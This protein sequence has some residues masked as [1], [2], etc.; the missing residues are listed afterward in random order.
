MEYNEWSDD[1]PKTCVIIHVGLRT[2]KEKEK[3]GLVFSKCS[4]VRVKGAVGIV[5]Q[6]KTVPNGQNIVIT[7][8]DSYL[9]TN[10]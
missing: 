3:I 7:N 6:M 2:P 4:I 10:D 5:S 9:I 8:S 1:A